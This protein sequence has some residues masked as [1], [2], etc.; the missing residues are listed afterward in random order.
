MQA[1]KH[2]WACESGQ[3][4][5]AEDC[6]RLRVW[7]RETA[8]EAYNFFF[9]TVGKNDSAD[10][11]NDAMTAWSEWKQQNYVTEC[12]EPQILEW[13]CETWKQIQWN[14]C[15]RVESLW[16]LLTV[17]RS[18]ENSVY[19]ASETRTILPTSERST[20]LRKWLM[21][22]FYM[23]AS[24]ESGRGHTVFHWLTFWVGGASLMSCHQWYISW[25]EPNGNFSL[26]LEGTSL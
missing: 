11:A 21:R 17:S 16:R 13:N 18:K 22:A 2:A 3:T 25:L 15:D 23:W 4:G 20:L 14:S 10:S 9:S 5:D 1:S 8:L 12:T 6:A 26:S 24:Q 7:V 19:S